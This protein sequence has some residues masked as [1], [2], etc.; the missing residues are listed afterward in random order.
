MT[1]NSPMVLIVEDHPM[2]RET[3]ANMFRLEGMDT[4]VVDRGDQALVMLR[5]GSPDLVMLD[6]ELAGEMSGLDVLL[7][8]RSDPRYAATPV[9]LHTCEPAVANMPEA[10]TA[11]L[12]LLKP[13][14]L[15]QLLR[16]TQRLIG[17]VH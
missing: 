3:L 10:K 11:D 17:P 15:D 6:V 7:A 13:A 16:L 4:L 9:V 14:D 1:T 5:T 8:I 2:M 12:V